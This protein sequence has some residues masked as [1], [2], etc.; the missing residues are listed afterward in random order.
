MPWSL[1][2]APGP[3]SN[4]AP[5][6]PTPTAANEIDP[7]V[8]NSFM[9][10][11]N[12]SSDSSSPSAQMTAAPQQPM[13]QMQPVQNNQTSSPYAT[14]ATSNPFASA[15]GAATLPSDHPFAQGMDSSLK[16]AGA[17][18][19]DGIIGTHGIDAGVAAHSALTAGASS[20]QSSVGGFMQGMGQN[21]GQMV[22]SGSDVLGGLLSNGAK[23]IGNLASGIGAGFTGNPNSAQ[24]YNQAAN[25]LQQEPA[26]QQKVAN[27]SQSLLP[28]A[29]GQSTLSQPPMSMSPQQSMA[30]PQNQKAAKPADVVKDSKG[31]QYTVN[32]DGSIAGPGGQTFVPDGAEKKKDGSFW[33]KLGETMQDV[34]AQL[35]GHPAFEIQKGKA[36]AG[37]LRAETASKQREMEAGGPE[38]D[39]ALKKQQTEASKA[40]LGL[41]GQE[42]QAGMTK[43]RRDALIDRRNQAQQMF[44]TELEKGTFWNK[45]KRLDALK[46]QLNDIDTQLGFGTQTQEPTAVNPKTNERMV[47]RGGKWQTL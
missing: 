20:S 29:N 39:V 17:A 44:N 43:A 12:N 11:I 9:S 6:S 26:Y 31:D 8:I 28:T 25:T 42:I 5:A 47:Y 10:L 35:Q 41:K 23:N 19:M 16:K 21:V 45:D 36:E 33:I 18:T 7:S 2:A 3:I 22:K 38:A 34:G 13:P 32:K 14:A 15:A 27:G 37:M 46:T 30:T 24:S 4:T 1:Q 40:E